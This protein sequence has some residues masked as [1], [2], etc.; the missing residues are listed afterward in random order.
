MKR[1]L[2]FPVVTGWL[3]VPFG[4][5]IMFQFFGSAYALGTLLILGLMQ[6]KNTRDLLSEIAWY[7]Q[8]GLEYPGMGVSPD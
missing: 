6:F 2:L 5:A 8:R 7:E 1:R 3:L 4:T